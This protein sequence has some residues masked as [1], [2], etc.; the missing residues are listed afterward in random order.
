[1]TGLRYVRVINVDRS[2][3]KFMSARQ[4]TSPNEVSVSG[5]IEHIIFRSDDSDF[6]VAVLSV[7]TEKQ[8][9]RLAGELGD[10]EVGETVSVMGK[11]VVDARFGPQIKVS[12]IAPQLPHTE[13]GIR[14]FLSSGR[15]EGIGPKLAKRLVSH[16]GEATIDIIANQPHR[17]AE[18][19]GIGVKRRREITAR[20]Q[21]GT[22]QREAMI[23]LHGLGLGAAQSLKIW[24]RYDKQSISLVSTNPYRLVND[25]R[26]IG[27]AKADGIALSLGITADSPTRIAAAIVFCLRSSLD[28]GNVFLPRAELIKRLGKLLGNEID[29]VSLLNELVD[30]A[31]LIEEED[32]I[33]L[34]FAAETEVAVAEFFST[35]SESATAIVPALRNE[36]L[37]DLAEGQ[38][39]AVRMLVEHRIC[40]LTGGP[41]TGKTTT[42]RTLLSVLM[43]R[44]KRVALAAPTG[45]A[46][47]RMSE[48]TGYVASTIHRL[49][50]YHPV[51]GFRVNAQAPLEVDVVIIDEASMID[52]NLMYA[53]IQALGK[54]TALIL[55]GDADQ[56]PSVGPGQVL[57]DVI[58]S[59]EVP[60][61]ALTEVFRQESNSQILQLAYDIRMGQKPA[62]NLNTER[63]DF[64]WIDAEKPEDALGYIE[65]MVSQRIPK[66]FALSAKGDIQVLCPMHKGACG[67]ESVNQ[68]LQAALNPEGTSLKRYPNFRLGDRIMQTS[69]DH[70]KEVYNGDLGFICHQD[71]DAVYI[72]FDGRVVS[73]QRNELDQLT[74]AYAVSI[75]KSQGSEY[76]AVVIPVLT[77]HWVMLSRNLLYTAVT[78]GKQLVILVGQRKALKQTIRQVDAHRRFTTLS[79]RI[80]EA[81]S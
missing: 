56:L 65:L 8:S 24:K 27:F 47:K 44:S 23:F 33:Y 28:D 48:S 25:V 43:S 79:K 20:V 11:L 75:H 55:V 9:M 81:L 17:L 3:W 68:R 50:G 12:A 77:E 67:T 19:S 15:I 32:A 53:L 64:Y 5:V 26:G 6:A 7:E 69:N 1:M 22:W 71:N 38:A 80:V 36:E 74:L 66:R 21:E 18:V 54:G 29:V 49:L 73:Y 61:A 14:R 34:P 70:Q 60:T 30:E 45:R 58:D 13:E 51:D 40:A 63:S 39:D 2:Q 76:P 72:D 52:Q 10:I 62:L 57:K 46:A 59:G 16:F 41:G 35:A 31:R 4:S 42:L 37:T 78:R